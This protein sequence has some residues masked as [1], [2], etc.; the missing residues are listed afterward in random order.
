M[1]HPSVLQLDPPNRV[2]FNGTTTT[3]GPTVYLALAAVR[4]AGERIPKAEL[5]RAVWGRDRTSVCVWALC[6]RLNRTFAAIGYRR[7]A[8]SD[9]EDV[10]IL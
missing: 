4:A 2:T 1:P 3:V 7:R 8:G 6:H 9:G 10:V 5:C